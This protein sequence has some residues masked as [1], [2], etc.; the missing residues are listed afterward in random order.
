MSQAPATL[1]QAERTGR[2]SLVS[3]KTVLSELGRMLHVIK[4]AA[5]EKRQVSKAEARV[6]KSSNPAAGGSEAKRKAAK[7][8]GKGE[9]R[10]GKSR[11]SRC[12]GSVW[13]VLKGGFDGHQVPVAG[14]QGRTSDYNGSKTKSLRPDVAL[15]RAAQRLEWVL[16]QRRAAVD[17]AESY[18]ASAWRE[19]EIGGLL[20]SAGGK[21]SKAARTPTEEGR[22]YLSEQYQAATEMV[23]GPYL[24]EMLHT[25]VRSTTAAPPPTSSKTSTT[26]DPSAW[27]PPPPPGEAIQ[28][29]LRAFQPQWEDLLRREAVLRHGL[30]EGE[31]PAVTTE[32]VKQAVVHSWRYVAE[33][34]GTAS[35]GNDAKPTKCI[36]RL[37]SSAHQKFS[38]VLNNQKAVNSFNTNIVKVLRKELANDSVLPRG[39]KDE[40][41]AKPHTH[42]TAGGGGGGGK[43]QSSHTQQQQQ[44]G[45]RGGKKKR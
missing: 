32:D 38:A 6:G 30:A 42:H 17:G 21:G 29:H 41:D 10:R 16:K 36:I 8:N 43:Q 3:E 33:A 11:H 2:R 45:K 22:A 15:A 14:A 20:S 37:R 28:Q 25:L 40:M 24:G 7:K 18:I 23:K 34:P 26:V 5:K 12:G 39:G 27:T 13:M 1:A 31:P 4:A 19:A 35:G 44:K 9:A